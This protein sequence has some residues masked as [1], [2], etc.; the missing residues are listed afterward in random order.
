MKKNPFAL[1]AMSSLILAAHSYA[2]PNQNS[3]LAA[4]SVVPSLS[5]NESA[6]IT[7]ANENT[8]TKNSICEVKMVMRELWEDNVSW[9]RNYIISEISMTGERRV[10]SRKL[11]QNQDNIGNAIKPYYGDTAGNELTNLLRNHF[12]ISE[13]IINAIKENNKT[14]LRTEQDKWSQNSDEIAIFLNKLNPNLNKNEISNTLQKNLDLTVAEAKA[15][16]YFDWNQDLKAYEENQKVMLNFS[17][18]LV[19]AIAKQFPEKFTK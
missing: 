10:I 8:P 1:I 19:D 16:A 6:E 12:S 14:E 3:S 5:V 9:I 11:L 17:D 18:Q 4:T 7:K 13:K 15:R 2:L